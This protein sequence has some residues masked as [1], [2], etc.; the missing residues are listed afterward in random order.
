MIFELLET[1]GLTFEQWQALV[2]KGIE[3]CES[4]LMVALTKIALNSTDSDIRF[5]AIQTLDISNGLDEDLVSKILS[6]D[7]DSEIINYLKNK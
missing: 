2:M 1:E 4:Q 5:N 6:I 3:F 7:K